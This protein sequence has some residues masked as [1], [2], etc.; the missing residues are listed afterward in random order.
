MHL[1][2]VLLFHELNVISAGRFKTEEFDHVMSLNTMVSP[3]IWTTLALI[4]CLLVDSCSCPPLSQSVC[5]NMTA[6]PAPNAAHIQP[7]GPASC[8]GPVDG[9]PDLY[10]IGIRVGIY[11]QL[12][13]TLIANHYLPDAMKVHQEFINLKGKSTALC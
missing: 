2:H 1:L 4:L 13:S 11:L 5:Q 3:M 12:F 6:S 10:G 7:R 8:L 9:N